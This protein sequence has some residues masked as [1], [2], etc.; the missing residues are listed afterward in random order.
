MKKFKTI[1]WLLKTNE[2]IE[3]DNLKYNRELE[4][5]YSL[6]NKKIIRLKELIKIFKQSDRLPLFIQSMKAIKEEEIYKS[7]VHGISHNE[8]VGFLSFAIGILE[9]LNEED[10]RL[11]L[12]LAKYHDVGRID[13]S[14][15]DL[16]GKRSSEKIDRLADWKN[17][18]ELR[19]LKTVSICHSIDDKEFEKIAKQNG[20]KDVDR[21]KKIFLVLKDADALDR[22]RI[23]NNGLDVNYLRTESAKNMIL[24]AYELFEN[25]KYAQ[26][27][28]EEEETI[29]FPPK[30]VFDK[31]LSQEQMRA[32]KKQWILFN[33]YSKFNI[34]NNELKKD[35]NGKLVLEEGTLI[36]GTSE[37]DKEKLDS[38]SR[39]GI[40]ACEF[41]GTYE[42]AETYYCADFMRVPEKQTLEKYLSNKANSASGRIPCN[43]SSSSIAFIVNPSMEIEELI[44]MDCYRNKDIRDI[45]NTNSSVV[46]RYSGEREGYASAILGGIPASCFSGIIVGDKILEDI[47]Q[48]KTLKQL[49]PNC[50]LTTSDGTI[51]HEVNIE[52]KNSEEYEELVLKNTRLKNENG[53]LKVKKGQLEQRYLEA[54]GEKAK[55]LEVLET[56][57]KDGEISLEV[58][59]KIYE[60]L[61]GKGHAPYWLQDLIDKDNKP[62]VEPSE[63]AEAAKKGTNITE[64]NAVDSYISDQI[65]LNQTKNKEVK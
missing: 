9:G 54:E 45:L 41:L 37:F 39:A 38:I 25:Y 50:Y 17:E 21:C 23:K 59:T 5:V 2:L 7:D 30:M 36:H 15:D 12:E 57:C 46:E 4:R 6:K 51:I 40:L 64:I 32:L 29:D 65:E 28:I 48:I 24:A 3:V 42:D 31:S 53:K 60:N 33:R 1:D 47:E 61:W 13:D 49:F 22:V 11:V 14:E 16:H 20:I 8:R 26:K 58:M 52:E 62:K 56:M 43:P 44:K 63:I 10:L 27:Q 18:E 19:I 34:K 55:I 35:E